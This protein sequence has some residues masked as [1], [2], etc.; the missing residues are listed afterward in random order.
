[1]DLYVITAAISLA[2]ASIIISVLLIHIPAQ[3]EAPVCSDCSFCVKGP[4]SLIQMNASAYLVRGL[5]LHNSSILAQYVWAYRPGGPLTP[6][7]R[8]I[9]GRLMC[10]NVTDGVAYATCIGS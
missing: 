8:L 5:I 7:E 2:I 3:T 10:L 4:V 9:C 6:G 1:M